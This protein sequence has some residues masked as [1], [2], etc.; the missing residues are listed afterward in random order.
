MIKTFYN[1]LIGFL[2]MTFFSCNEKENLNVEKVISTYSLKS[3]GNF[4]KGGKR[5]KNKWHS[6]DSSLAFTL[7]ENHKTNH[8]LYIIQNK[9]ND[10][11]FKFFDSTRFELRK[12]DFFK[13]NNN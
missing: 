7:Y 10:T 9:K 13:S 4:A 2:I 5:L 6:K 1:I 8:F 3:Y 11:I 12:R